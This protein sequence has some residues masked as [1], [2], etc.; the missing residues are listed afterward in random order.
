MTLQPIAEQIRHAV[1]Q[2]ST[3]IRS[4]RLSGFE[5]LPRPRMVVFFM[6]F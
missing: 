4:K 6:V 5:D 3:A 2:A 1:R